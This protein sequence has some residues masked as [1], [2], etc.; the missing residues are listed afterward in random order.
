MYFSDTE[1]RNLIAN[2]SKRCINR[3]EMIPVILKYSHLF[4][5]TELKECSE[6]NF[7]STINALFIELRIKKQTK[8]ECGQII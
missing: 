4:G 7:A 3:E 5:E 6:Q 1:R 8:S 2:N